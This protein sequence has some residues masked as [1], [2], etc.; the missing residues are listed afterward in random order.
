VIQGSEGKDRVGGGYRGWREIAFIEFVG[1]LGF[2]GLMKQGSVE[3]CTRFA[4]SIS[5][6][7]TNPIYARNTLKGSETS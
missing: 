6:N 3:R 5:I 7:S 4:E 1:F 2:I